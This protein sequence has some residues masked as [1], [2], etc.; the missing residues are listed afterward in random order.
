MSFVAIS[1]HSLQKCFFQAFGF[2]CN[3]TKTGE[4]FLF[5]NI[6]TTIYCHPSF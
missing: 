5:L 6:L 1:G 4:M 3:D 2:L